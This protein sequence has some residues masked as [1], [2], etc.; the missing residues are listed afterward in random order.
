[1][2]F[3]PCVVR[4]PQDFNTDDFRP[5]ILLRKMGLR[6]YGITNDGIHTKISTSRIS[7]ELVLIF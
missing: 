7:Y 5:Q 6:V 1:M 4:P 2:H 3:Q